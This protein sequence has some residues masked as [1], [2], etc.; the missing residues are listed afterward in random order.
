MSGCEETNKGRAQRASTV[1]SEASHSKRAFMQTALRSLNRQRQ[2]AD[3]ES[4][5][6]K[7][8]SRLH[9][10]LLLLLVFVVLRFNLFV[11]EFE[12]LL[13]LVAVIRFPGI[14]SCSQ[15]I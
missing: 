9:R 12:L 8:L 11:L 6:K 10:L 15:S 4:V 14:F 13:Q 7:Q 3:V 2:F 1:H 5:Y